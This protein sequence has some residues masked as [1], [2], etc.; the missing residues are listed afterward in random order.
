[1]AGSEGGGPA[2]LEGPFYSSGGSMTKKSAPKGKPAARR[3]KATP[4]VPDGRRFRSKPVLIEAVKFTGENVAEI[5]ELVPDAW[6]TNTGSLEVGTLGGPAHAQPGD[7]VV[8]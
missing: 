3:G 4:H 7:W 2:A 8:K 6:V 5:Q 1:M